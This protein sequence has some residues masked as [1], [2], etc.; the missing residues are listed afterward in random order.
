MAGSIV[1]KRRAR[2]R[3]IFFARAEWLA[4]RRR[5]VSCPVSI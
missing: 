2:E 5:F 1:A 3:A 4:F